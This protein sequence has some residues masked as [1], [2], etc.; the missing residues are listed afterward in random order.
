MFGLLYY[1]KNRERKKELG[2][3]KALGLSD[4]DSLKLV[5]YNMCKNTVCTIV[6][7]ILFSV[8]IQLIVNKLLEAQLITMSVLTII[9]CIVISV[10]A[11]F[12]SGMVSVYKTSKI[13]IIDAIQ[14]NR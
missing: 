3:L 13:D 11:V 5:G 1:Y 7:A 10:I 12:A 2:I 4:S 6:L 14:T 8:A 9:I